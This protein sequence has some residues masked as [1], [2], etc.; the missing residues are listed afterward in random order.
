MKSQT[1]HLDEAGLIRSV[2]DM[3][4]LSADVRHHLSECPICQRKKQQFEQELTSLE[5]MAE[6]FAPLPRKRVM[7][8][9]KPFGKVS[10]YT[11]LRPV[12][13]AGTAIVL[14]VLGILWLPA[15]LT[16]S[17]NEQTEHSQTEQIARVVEEM[18]EDRQLMAEIRDLEED[19]LPDFYQGI[20]GESYG[21][22]DEDFVD[23]VVPMEETRIRPAGRFANSPD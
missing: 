2:V 8:L 3:N 6:A 16:I 9:E 19:A 4:D 7:Y 22:F 17:Q 5:R 14:L 21:Y 1:I 10:F 11:L 12:F 20:S 15:P 13:A 18:E 23:F